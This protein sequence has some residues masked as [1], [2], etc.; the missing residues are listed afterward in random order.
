M[1]QS[2]GG[3]GP[4]GPPSFHRRPGRSAD[5]ARRHSASDGGEL[6]AS[7]PGAAP[8]TPG[9]GQRDGGTRGVAAGADAVT[10][11]RTD[12]DRRREN[13]VECYDAAREAARAAARGESGASGRAPGRTRRRRS[14]GGRRLDT[15]RSTVRV[16]LAAARWSTAR[17]RRSPR[18][19][20]PPPNRAWSAHDVHRNRSR[21]AWSASGRWMEVQW[22]LVPNRHRPTVSRAGATG[23]AE[24]GSA[25]IW[26]LAAGMVMLLLGVARSRPWVRPS[27]PATGPGATADLALAGAGSAR[28]SARETAACALERPNSWRP[29]ARRSRLA[30]MSPRR[31]RRH[32]PPGSPLEGLRRSPGL[33]RRQRRREPARPNPIRLTRETSPMWRTMAAGHHPGGLRGRPPAPG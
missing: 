28:C 32:R 12:R 18:P 5:G 2:R 22:R 10:V 9:P 30:A 3:G 27:W 4:F 21:L 25:T 31:P 29:T 15:V 14:F 6:S 23:E 11:R 26:V 7:W 16:H 17:V 1:T 20:S 33:R 19:R 13:A 24:R 8:V